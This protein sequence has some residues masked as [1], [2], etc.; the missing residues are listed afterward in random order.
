MYLCPLAVFLEVM[1]FGQKILPG[2]VR[3]DKNWIF[4]PE[5]KL[6][7]KRRMRPSIDFE[8][9]SYLTRLQKVICLS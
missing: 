8:F 5:Q 7:C 2:W 9:R 6:K 1:L 4:H 3:G